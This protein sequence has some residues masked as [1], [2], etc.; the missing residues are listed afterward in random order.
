MYVVGV[1]GFIACFFAYLGQFGHKA[2]A[3][4]IASGPPFDIQT[5]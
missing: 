5:T 3:F 1:L 2:T 4:V